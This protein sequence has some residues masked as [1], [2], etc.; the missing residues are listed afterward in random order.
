MAADVSKL[1]EGKKIALWQKI[2]EH[3]IISIPGLMEIFSA[4][5]Q[6]DFFFYLDHDYFSSFVYNSK[7]F[8]FSLSAKCLR[9]ATVR[10]ILNRYIFVTH[11]SVSS[12]GKCTA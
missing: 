10:N 2:S 12:Q 4:F 9:D 3:R 8:F 7:I 6:A 5:L 11:I 1:L